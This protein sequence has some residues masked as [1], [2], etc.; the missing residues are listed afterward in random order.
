MTPLDNCEVVDYLFPDYDPGYKVLMQGLLKKRG[1]WN[2]A[3]QSRSL[4]LHASSG[5]SNCFRENDKNY[6]EHARGI[7]PIDVQAVIESENEGVQNDS[8]GIIRIHVPSNGVATSR[9]IVLCPR[10]R[11][12]YSQW[13]EVLS[14]VQQNVQH[15]S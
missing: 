10:N 1:R 2:S 6:P 13:I 3:W 8:I 5:L 4:V 14:L 11:I 9:T 7:I 12:V 15:I